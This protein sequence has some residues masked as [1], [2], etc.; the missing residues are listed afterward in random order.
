M[1]NVDEIIQQ[2]EFSYIP[3]MN[4]NLPL[5]G[6]ICQFLLKVNVNLTYYTISY[7]QAII[8]SVTYQDT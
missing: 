5:W 3:S 4:V 1:L 7:Y 6:N 8:L 2:A